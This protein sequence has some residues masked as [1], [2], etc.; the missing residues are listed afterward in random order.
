MNQM[1]IV[2]VRTVEFL[3]F[4]IKPSRPVHLRNLC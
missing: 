1:K 2:V 4:Q 3:V